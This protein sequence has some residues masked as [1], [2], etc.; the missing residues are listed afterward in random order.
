MHRW[1]REKSNGQKGP[2]MDTTLTI[3]LSHQVARRRQ[4]SIIANNIANMST[5]AFKRENV[6]FSQYVKEVNGS[7]PKSVRNISY[8]QDLGVARNMKD[9]HL[10][11]TGNLFDI[12]LNGDGMFQV[13]RGNG[14]LAY[15]RNGHLALSPDYTLITSTGQEIMD[16]S[17]KSIK[18]PPNITNIKIA[19]DGTISSPKT[20]QIAKLNVVRFTNESSLKKI[21]ENMF[22]SDAPPLPATNYHIIQ[23]MIEGSNVQPIIELTRMI[24]V[25]RSYIETAKL[26]DNLQRA[27]SRAINLLGK[28][29]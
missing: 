8:V 12:A 3:A 22:N 15:T 4:M 1:N 14:D 11:T 23:G 5:T 24:E 9:G 25:S 10:E 7:L 6:M 29:G 28:V 17:G 21:G 16:Q 27:R 18:I 26:I 19:E 2:K 13:K 20:G